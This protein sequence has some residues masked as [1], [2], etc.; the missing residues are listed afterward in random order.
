MRFALGLVPKALLLFINSGV[1][2]TQTP[3]TPQTSSS[4]TVSS[5]LS[6]ISLVA[7]AAMADNSMSS[8][9][10]PM[11]EVVLQLENVDESF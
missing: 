9:K 5:L 2:S 1:Q 11:N 3:E 7:I 8:R 6:T 10:A 4:V